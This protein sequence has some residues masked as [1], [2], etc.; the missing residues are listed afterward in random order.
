MGEM[1]AGASTGT[2]RFVIGLNKENTMQLEKLSAV[3]RQFEVERLLSRYA[4]CIDDDRLE[5]WPELFTED[6]IYRV[7]PREN[8]DRGLPVAVMDCDSRG[9]LV[10]RVVS[11][12]NANIYPE[13]FYRHL[14]SSVHVKGVED[15]QLVV[16][17]N[18]VV[19]QTRNDGETKVY[20]AGKYLDRI[21]VE[22]GELRFKEK[23]VIFDT[24][25]IGTLMA[26]PI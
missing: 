16:Q 3:E 24:Y 4:E 5:E 23:L 13:H 20:N 22:A 2:Y 21:V 11:L 25:S 19:L 7:V 26:R 8:A 6:A 12:R 17:S 14:V 9:M 18:Y 15:G 10:D 1:T